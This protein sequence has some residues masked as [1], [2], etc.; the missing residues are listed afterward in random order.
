MATSQSDASQYR[1]AAENGLFWIGVLTAL[2]TPFAFF[3]D[4]LT[5]SY[6]TGQ[7]DIQEDLTTL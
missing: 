3:M 2:G 5:D 4:V 7:T 6:T 1:L